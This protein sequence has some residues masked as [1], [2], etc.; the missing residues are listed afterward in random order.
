MF[1]SDDAIKADARPMGD[2]GWEM[3]KGNGLTWGSMNRGTPKSTAFRRI[4]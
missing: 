4:T 1:V 3:N 2:V